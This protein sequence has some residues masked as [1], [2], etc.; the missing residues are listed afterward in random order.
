MT[1]ADRTLFS[2]WRETHAICAGCE[3]VVRKDWM[4]CPYC[5]A[6]DHVDLSVTTGQRGPLMCEP[7]TAADYETVLADHRRLV[8]ELDVALNGYGA[9][10]Q[11]SLCDIVAQ[12]Q[13]WRREA[14]HLTASQ[15]LWSAIYNR[16]AE[17]S[18]PTECQRSP[19]K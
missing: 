19:E 1:E 5:G 7:L 2:R 14:K 18:A 4:Y 8:Y 12:V 11:T 13:Q 10:P 6:Q 15:S 3:E 9:S 17:R 16:S